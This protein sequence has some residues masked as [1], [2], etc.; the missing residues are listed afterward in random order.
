MP[1]SAWLDGRLVPLDGAHLSITDRG[2]QLGDGL[3][4]SLRV[5]RGTLIEWP[6]HLARLHAGAAVLAIPL[7][8]DEVLEAGIRQLLAAEGL[9][10]T[11]RERPG[12]AAVRITVTRGPIGARGTLPLGWGT[13]RPT[14]AIQAWPYEA[15]PPALLEGGIRAVTSGL[16]RDPASPLAGVKSTSRADYVVARLEAERA[17]ADDAMFTT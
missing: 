17:G 14:V 1:R 9:D 11:D 10:S 6:E 7:V 15:P 16:R 8:P 5:R 3:F 13:G 2:F 4:E 12:D